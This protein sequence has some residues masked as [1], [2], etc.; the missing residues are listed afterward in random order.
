MTF[1]RSLCPLNSCTRRIWLRIG[2]VE[3]SAMLCVTIGG[4]ELRFSANIRRLRRMRSS[5]VRSFESVGSELAESL[6][7]VSH[8]SSAQIPHILVD[9]LSYPLYLAEASNSLSPIFACTSCTVSLS[10][11]ITACPF[12]ASIVYECVCAGMMMNATTVMGVGGVREDEGDAWREEEELDD[13]A[14][15]ALYAAS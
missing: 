6:V 12:S 13:S 14:T 2:S 1:T 10:C 9:T 11:L 3:S 7:E 5:S 15:A 8:S 4:S